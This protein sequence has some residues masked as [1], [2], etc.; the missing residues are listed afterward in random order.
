MP[1][2][3][4]S[5]YDRVVLVC[6]RVLGLGMLIEPEPEGA[7]GWLNVLPFPCPEFDP[8]SFPEPESVPD[9]DLKSDPEPAANLLRPCPRW[10]PRRSLFVLLP[11]LPLLPPSCRCISAN[12]SV[13]GVVAA[14]NFSPL[15][16]PL[17]AAASA[18]CGLAFTWW[19]SSATPRDATAPIFHFS[20]LSHLRFI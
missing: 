20:H 16:A 6:V 12:G 17:L 3:S 13:V 19:N 4:C 15:S 2:A 7:E 8:W 9:P 5:A 1:L 10:P 11:K 14:A 18:N